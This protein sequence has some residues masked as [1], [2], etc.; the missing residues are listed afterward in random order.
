MEVEKMSPFCNMA[1]AEFRFSA[2]RIL[3]VFLMEHRQKPGA[4]TAKPL[5][6]RLV[7]WSIPVHGSDFP[8]LRIK[9]RF[10]P[11]P[12]RLKRLKALRHWIRFLKDLSGCHRDEL[13]HETLPRTAWEK[14][15][16]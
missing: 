6:L 16:H 11:L 1:A 15:Q 5:D 4:V 3:G 9:Q 10:M 14:G 13:M 12:Q 8:I 7:Q 2:G